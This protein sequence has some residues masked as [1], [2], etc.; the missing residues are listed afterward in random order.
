[1]K[2]ITQEIASR[3]Y[4]LSPV[5]VAFY[6]EFEAWMTVLSRSEGWAGKKYVFFAK[7]NLTELLSWLLP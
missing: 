6:R 3:N 5:E 7:A 4:S 2:Q 1:M